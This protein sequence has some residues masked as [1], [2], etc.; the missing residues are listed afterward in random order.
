MHTV[1]PNYRN[2]RALLMALAQDTRVIVLDEFGKEVV[3]G[4][5]TV[6]GPV[7][8]WAAEAPLWAAQVR[9]ANSRIVEVVR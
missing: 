3:E 9:V 7:G 1:L 6:E 8:E 4:L 5:V 2:R